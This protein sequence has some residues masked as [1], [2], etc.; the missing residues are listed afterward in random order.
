MV[1]ENK[2]YVEDE[3]VTLGILLGLHLTWQLPV[4]SAFA[5]WQSAM[6]KLLHH[7]VLVLGCFASQ[8]GQ[9]HGVR[10]SWTI[11]FEAVSQRQQFLPYIGVF[12]GV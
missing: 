1:K 7:Q 2:A 10:R 8:W 9:R 6:E 4:L 3:V 11:P 5:S 12:V